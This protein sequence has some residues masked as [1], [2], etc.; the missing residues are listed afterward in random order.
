MKKIYFKITYAV[1]LMT[2]L[3]LIACTKSYLDIKPIGSVSVAILANK[4]GV[5]K[6][7]IGAYATLETNHSNSVGYGDGYWVG[8]G[9]FYSDIASHEAIWGF[10]YEPN[11]NSF[12]RHDGQPSYK[13][14]AYHWVNFYYGV[15]AANDVLRVLAEVPSGQLTAA[16][17]LQIK[18][19]ATFLRALHHFRLKKT[20]GNV[21]YIDETIKANNCNVSNATSI[22]PQIEADFKFA[23]DNLDETKVDVGRANKWAAK[24]FLAEVYMQQGKYSD[25]L[26]LLTS[27]ITN[28]VTQKGLKY[29]LVANYPDILNF[30]KEANSEQVFAIQFTFDKTSVAAP[31]GNWEYAVIQPVTPPNQGGGGGFCSFDMVNAFKTDA[32]TGLPMF[33]TYNDVN[34]KNDQGLGLNDAFVPYD[35]TVDPRLDFTVV[36]RGIPFFDWGLY[37]VNWAYDQPETGPYSW[38]KFSFSKA[39]LAAVQANWVAVTPINV[40]LIRFADILLRAAE[41]LVETGGSLATAEGYV[42]QVRQRAANQSAWVKTYVNN[43]SP[44]LGFTNTPAANYFISAYSGQFAANG[45][46]YARKAIRFERR[47]E[48]ALESKRFFDLQRWDA[49]SGSMA[50]ELNRIL[51]H[52]RSFMT[53]YKGIYPNMVGA[54]FT[55]GKNEVFPIPQSQIDLSMVEGK[56]VLVQN[57]G[58]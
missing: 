15:Q 3:S 49:G 39:D 52:S 40:P 41:C 32:V 9:P 44:A 25:A 43:T 47:L 28:G 10:Q 23:A 45:A 12:E 1:C 29:A 21:P 34:M 14:F 35:G 50:T 38:K 48:L 51:D 6:V 24:A 55:K 33:D 7:L 57:P 22:W 2:M 13:V 42:N 4:T 56:P 53:I 46:T 27:C 20:F 5:N 18:A 16:E 30:R 19:E 37:N 58:Y 8:Y 31:N 54:K 11:T 17:A 36:R 26:P